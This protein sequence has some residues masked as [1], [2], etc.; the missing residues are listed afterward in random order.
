MAFPRV[1]PKYDQGEKGEAQVRGD[2][3]TIKLR[4]EESKK[5][6]KFKRTRNTAKL[7]PGKWFVQ[8]DGDNSEIFS[9]HPWS[10]NLKGKV[11]EFSS[12]ENEEPVPKL[13]NVD[14]YNN[15][16]KH[17]KYSY[18]YFV[19]IFEILE[20]KK[21]AG[22][23][24]P[25]RLN[26]NFLEA[27]NDQNE[28]IVGLMSKG[29]RTKDLAEFLRIS[30][31]DNGVEIE[32][33]DNI[34]PELEKRILDADQSFMFIIKNGWIDTLYEVDEPESAEDELSWDEE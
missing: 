30:G 19:V 18:Y 28:S 29:N 12:R 1:E 10:G 31:A 33:S 27:K 6:Y 5:V 20:P 14:Y 34:L 23:S 32:W 13:K 15:E 16:G 11:S 8:L 21:Y 26:Y 9:F 2:K 17:I 3:K 24:V 4:F 25:F 7:R 22:I